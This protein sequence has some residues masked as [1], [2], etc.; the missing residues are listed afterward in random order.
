MRL[1]KKKVQNKDARKA[2]TEPGKY[3]Y[4]RKQP[5]LCHRQ[6]DQDQ[7]KVISPKNFNSV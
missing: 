5:L 3:N 4:L 7:E 2:G 1:L 6:K